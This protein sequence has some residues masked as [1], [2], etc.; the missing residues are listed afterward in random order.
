MYET[1]LVSMPSGTRYWT[2]VD[3]ELEV[4]QEADRFLREVLLAQGRAET[5]TKA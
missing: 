4:V 2:V 1:F 3:D 5:T